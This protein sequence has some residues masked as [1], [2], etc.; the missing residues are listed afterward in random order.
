MIDSHKKFQLPLVIIRGGGDLATGAAY[1]LYKSGWPVL[2]T[3]L[4]KPR[5]VRRTVCMGEAVWDGNI[6]IEGVRAEKT[7]LDSLVETDGG[8][9]A[10]MDKILKREVIGVTV[11]PEGL[12]IK[13]LRPHILVDARMTKLKA[14][15]Q[16]AEGRLTVGIGPGFEA[17]VNVDAVIET[18]RGITLGKVLYEGSAIP[19]TG[20]PGVVGGESIRRL[21]KAPAAGIFEAE[22]RIGDLVKAGQL[23]GYVAGVPVYVQIDGLLRGLIRNG[24]EVKLDEKIGDCDPRGSKVD[25]YTISDKSR[26]IG[27]GVLEAACTFLF[28]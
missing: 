22:A 17:G 9:S 26:A 18:M 16:R 23:V 6:E 1:R 4:E 28:A 7:E 27:G 2:I 11:D 13:A 10:A 3:E 15:D 12:S 20:V 25:V 14:E 19:N 5:M 21:L 8:T 24:T